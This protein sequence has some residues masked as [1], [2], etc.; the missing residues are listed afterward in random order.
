MNVAFQNIGKL[1]P[2]KSAFDLSYDVKLTCDMGELIP[3]MAKLMVPGDTFKYAVEDVVRLLPLATPIY[4]E[5]IVTNHTFFIPIRI[6][7]KNFDRYISGGKD[8]NYVTPIPKW[9]PT[10]DDLK[11]FTLWDYFGFPVTNYTIPP[12]DARNLPMDMLRRAYNYI[13]DEYYRDQNYDE[14]INTGD[15]GK[16]E[17][18]PTV[19]GN[20]RKVL[21]RRWKK[22]YFTSALPFRQRGT[23]PALPIAGVLRADFER[24]ANY[25]ISTDGNPIGTGNI[26]YLGV[27]INN[28]NKAININRSNAANLSGGQLGQATENLIGALNSNTIKVNEAATC[29]VNDLR[30]V[31]QLQKWMER[32]ARAGVRYKEFIDVH[33]DEHIGDSTLQRPEYVGGTKTFINVNEVV[34]TMQFEGLSNPQG[35]MTGHGL[36]ADEGYVGTYH[37]REF[38]IIMNITS[39]MP[40]PC[41]EDGFEREWM[42]NDKE[43]WYMPEYAHL[44]EQAILNQEV[45]PKGGNPVTTEGKPITGGDLDIWAYQGRYDE[46]RV[47]KDK[48]VSEMRVK[49]PSS[50]SSMADWHLSRSFTSLP[51]LNSNFLECN[52]DKRVFMVM[53]GQSKTCIINHANLIKAI[54][55]LPEI[56]E[57]GL[58]DH[59]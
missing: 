39:I 47:S 35:T 7:M 6:L 43:E 21:K 31:V 58:M 22:D 49:V 1:H 55:P 32:N 38:G 11:L 2:K 8:G 24:L 33:F 12:I 10:V 29:D 44:S 48:V 18:P 23:A 28:N 30:T 36:A 54:R 3:T 53:E 19:W 16:T 26:A 52:P 42:Y 37:A 14:P 46:L 17:T 20:N 9:N 59:F 57:P 45:F 41:Y 25:T 56:A 34:S 13:W 5:I 50:Y 15:D 27:S 4:H 40:K 51:N